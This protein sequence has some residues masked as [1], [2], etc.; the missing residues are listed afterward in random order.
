MA[1][2]FSSLLNVN[3]FI[4]RI[5]NYR[6]QLS[7]LAVYIGMIL[8]FILLAPQAFLHKGIYF[9]ILRAIP[10]F[11]IM[12]VAMT[13]LMTSGEIDL[14]IGSILAFSSGI[15]AL[16]YR[17]TG[18]FF[19]AVP[20][21]LAVGVFAGLVNSIVTLKF[22]IPSLIV[23]LGTM[24][25]WRGA[26]NVLTSGYGKFCPVSGTTFYNVLVGEIWGGFPVQMFWFIAIML[27]F[28]SVLNRHKFGNWISITGDNIKAAQAMGINTDTVKLI[29]FVMSGVMAS[30]AGIIQTTRVCYFFP[31]QGE[32]A[33]FDVIAAVAIGGTALGGGAGSILGTFI[34]VFIIGTLDSGLI[35]AGASGFHIRLAIGLVIILAV[36]VNSLIRMRRR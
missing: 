15:F 32:L 27:F 8:A 20:G 3:N 14:S 9:A 10:E 26:T 7:I 31:T 19:L 16:L 24:I 34:G 30:F 4:L 21:A 5:R 13:L 35:A 22:R 25:A 2:K 18:S 33:L 6:Q 17:S 29:T 11:G 1:G 36:V 28:W 12:C 23:T